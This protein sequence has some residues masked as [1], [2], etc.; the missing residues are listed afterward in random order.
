MVKNLQINNSGKL[1]FDK[2]IIN[3]IVGYLKNELEFTINDV[4]VNFI[5]SVEITLLNVKYLKH[6]NSTDIITFNY[7]GNNHNL[8]GEIFISVEDCRN[9][10]VQFGVKFQEELLRLIIHGFL[11]LLGY[12]DE[13]RSDKKK[14]F[15][16]Q[17]YLLNNC[18]FAL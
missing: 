12:N 6:N 2:R 15:E 1:E 13:N 7:S 18:K 9:N 14:M 5:S 10:A 11:H 3:S 16:L 4:S 8:D 17:E